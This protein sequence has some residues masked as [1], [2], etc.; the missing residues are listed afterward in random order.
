MGKG[1]DHYEMLGVNRK[2]TLDEIRR[3]YRR[4]ALKIHPDR[5][6]APDAADRFT[7]LTQAYEVL[8]DPDARRRYDEDLT[9]QTYRSQPV[10]SRPAPAPAK[11][12]K[13]ATAQKMTTP[14]TARLA[15]LFS[16]GKMDEAE[17]L[18][19][20]IVENFPR[21]ALAYAIL[22]DIARARGEMARASKLYAFAVQMDPRNHAYQ[23]RYEDLLRSMGVKQVAEPANPLAASAA[24]FGVALLACVYLVVANEKPL[25]K[26]DLPFIST[27][28]LG[29]IVMLFLTGVGAGVALSLGRM[30]DRFSSVSVTALGRISPTVALATVAIVNFWAA[31]A[32]YLFLGITQQSFNFSASRLIGASVGGLLILTMGASLSGSIDAG[33]VLLWGGNVLYLGSISGWMVGDALR[34][35]V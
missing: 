9:R 26:N 2:A 35:P 10:P 34:R 1:P 4:L 17:A 8:R 21:E 29:C 14:E 25:F 13:V 27:W 30:L 31:T 24:A 20:R 5:S 3:A 11:P 33:Q 6:D 32:L 23:Q 18:A 19:E 15:A 7:R 28:T 22:G 16:R 12:K